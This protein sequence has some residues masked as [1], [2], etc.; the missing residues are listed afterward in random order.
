MD[1]LLKYFIVSGL[2]V[3]VF[4]NTQCIN[5]Q[6][7]PAPSGT[8][9]ISLKRTDIY[10]E[11]RG[12]SLN[13]NWKFYQGDVSGHGEISAYG[14]PGEIGVLIVQVPVDSIANNVGLKE[15]DVILKCQDQEIDNMNNLVKIFSDITKGTKVMLDI[16]RLQQQESIEVVIE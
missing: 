12:R 2:A 7:A 8:S 5:T 9:C 4:L 13:E 15:G 1:K 14:L 3:T 16:W 6:V 10:N 11:L